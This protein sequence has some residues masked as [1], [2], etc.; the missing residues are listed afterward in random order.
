LT[1]FAPDALLDAWYQEGVT[2]GGIGSDSLVRLLDIASNYSNVIRSYS[3]LTSY[4]LA[5]FGSGVGIPGL[6]ISYLDPLYK[7]TLVD[8][9]RKRADLA[10]K[11]VGLLNLAERCEV[12]N[13][14][15]EDL[16]PR[17][18]RFDIVVAR[19]FSRTSIF[20]ELAAPLLE[21]GGFMVLTSPHDDHESRWPSAG[22][23][24]L[25]FDPVDLITENGDNFA[26]IRKVG[27]STVPPRGY[28]KI[29]KA[30]VW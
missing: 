6:L 28:A 25:G 10:S 26:L 9:M 5:D 24:R 16:N 29:V 13:E 18:S 27:P 14:R 30:P 21:V 1:P 2:I 15:V 8:A 22:L 4:R 11:Y 19:C 20:S 23:K 7:V 12:L 17:K 3:S